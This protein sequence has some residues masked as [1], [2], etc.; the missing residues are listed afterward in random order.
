MTRA[1]VPTDALAPRP[2]EAGIG[3]MPDTRAL[4][5]YD[6]DPY[7]RFL[8]ARRLPAHERAP[9]EA[10][11]R[12]LGGQLGAGVEDLAAEADRQTPT[13]R[14]HDRRGERVDEVVPSRAYREL[15][16]LLYGRFGLA[17]MSLREGVASLERRAT[18]LSNDA[19]VYLAE[20]AESGL[21]CP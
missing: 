10:L 3:A 5:F 4:N 11:L 18:L 8:L 20:Q 1:A 13:L 12:E 7:L 14:T 15:E 16:R 19:L 21:F 9:A 6:A 17:A 2:V